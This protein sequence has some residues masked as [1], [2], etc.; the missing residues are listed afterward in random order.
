MQNIAYGTRALWYN[1]TKVARKSFQ[2][3][4]QT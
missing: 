4:K 1:N 2:I 3:N